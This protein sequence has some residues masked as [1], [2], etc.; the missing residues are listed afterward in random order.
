M[1]IDKRE[2]KQRQLVLN[3][4]FIFSTLY[5][6]STILNLI[7]NIKILEFGRLGRGRLGRGR[8]MVLGLIGILDMGV[9]ISRILSIRFWK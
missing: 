1:N 4:Y 5:T 7:L 3:I 8:F 2:G 6:S 9:L